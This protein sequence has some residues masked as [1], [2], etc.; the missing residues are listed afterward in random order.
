[1][2]KGV[3]DPAGGQAVQEGEF[4]KDQDYEETNQ[5]DINQEQSISVASRHSSHERY[6]ARRTR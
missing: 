1:V 5:D 4:R 6:F 2:L 3:F